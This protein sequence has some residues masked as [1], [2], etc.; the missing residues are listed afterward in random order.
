[1]LLRF[2]HFWSVTSH[3]SLHPVSCR[4]CGDCTEIDTAECIVGITNELLVRSRVPCSI[5]RHLCH[6]FRDSC[7]IFPDRPLTSGLASCL[8]HLP[9]NSTS[10]H[11]PHIRYWS[12]LSLE[13]SL[14]RSSCRSGA[15]FASKVC[16][17]P[18]YCPAQFQSGIGN[19]FAHDP[20]VGPVCPADNPALA[21][22]SMPSLTQ[23]GQSRQDST[24]RVRNSAATEIVFNRLALVE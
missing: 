22:I 7:S 21:T 15:T 17:N 9:R 18:A 12:T 4:S 20:F 11:H 5:G 13:R 2:V 3:S 1:M 19:E 14:S 6:R 16:S 10:H 24:F 23:V 8:C